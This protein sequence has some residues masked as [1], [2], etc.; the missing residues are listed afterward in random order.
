VPHSPRRKVLVVSYFFPP[1]GGAGVQ[2]VLKFVK[3]LPEHG[4]EPIVLTTRSRDYPAKDLSLLRE[5]PAGTP[6][7]CARDTALLRRAAVAFDYLGLR[8]LRALAVWPDEAAAW[9]PAAT[10]RALRSVRH[11]RPRL[12]FSSAPPFSAHLVG[13]MTARATD[14]PWVADFRDEFSAN[15]HAETHTDL[16]QRLNEPIERRIVA[17]AARVVTVA[18]YFAV[19]SAPPASARRVT[20]VNGVDA[21]D[22]ANLSRE[23]SA[24][25]FRLSFVGTLYGDRDLAPVA[26]ALAR[27]AARGIIDPACCE[28]R[29][30]GSMWLHKK[31]DAGAVPVVATGYL[32]HRE[33]VAQMRDATVLLF[34]AADSSP[35]PSGKIFEYLACERPILCVARSDN[36]AYHLVEEWDAGAGAEPRNAPAIESAIATMYD[37]WDRGDLDAPTG[38]RAKVLAHYSRR[39]LAGELARIF[40]AAVAS[41]S[42][43]ADLDES[44]R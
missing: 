22:V 37:R 19:E 26:A 7:A 15:P 29:I 28:L 38:V 33:A 35:A 40:D 14:L 18:D 3:Y 1:L 27:L 5:I 16:V 10:I 12:I 11:H 30:V 20:L 8:E 21:V 13:W 36:L 42:R 44:R 4:Y 25:K 24:D 32:D 6:I 17:D 31:P 23:Q 2:R 34:Y 41:E 43:S 9:I 39:Q